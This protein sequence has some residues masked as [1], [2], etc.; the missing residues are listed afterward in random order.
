[1][2]NSEINK[3]SNGLAEIEKNNNKV[4]GTCTKALF[5]FVKNKRIIDR[6]NQDYEEAYA[7]ILVDFRN[8]GKLDERKD[9][10]GEPIIK[11]KPDYVKEWNK[12]IKELKDIDVELDDITPIKL[13]DIEGCPFTIKDLET[14]EFMIEE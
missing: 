7:S 11:V 5:Y 9:T 2:R 12:R 1:M 10:N 4:F 8:D 13:A 6:A 3:I 14:L